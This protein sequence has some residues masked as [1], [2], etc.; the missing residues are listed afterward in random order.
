VSYL[1]VFRTYPDVDHMAPLAWKLLEQGEEVHAIVSPGYD[2]SADHRL[3]LLRGYRRYHEHSVEPAH[4]PRVIASALAF[5]RM[6]LPYAIAF[7]AR[8]NVRLVAV[9]WGYGL[10]EGYDRLAS[11]RGAVA[12]LRSLGRSFARAWRGDPRQP[13]TSYLIAARLLGRATVCLPHG[14]SIKLDAVSATADKGKVFDWSDRNRFDAYVLN[15]EHHRR[16]SVEHAKGDPQVMQTWGSLRWS[17]EWFE[18][19]RRL[20]PPFD[21]PEPTGE[22][23]LKVVLMT[24]KWRNRVHGERV[25]SMVKRIQG[26][27]FVSLAIK[28]HPRPEE[29]R[30]DPLRVD[31]EIDWNRIHDVTGED[32]VSVIRAA[33][34]IIDVGS[35][36]GIETVMQNKVLMNPRYVHELTTF[37][38]VIPGTCVCPDDD[39]AVE[40]YLRDHAAGQPHRVSAEAYEE[41]LRRAVYGSRDE[42][43][44]VI[45]DY[46]RRVSELAVA[47][48]HDKQ[49]TPATA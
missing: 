13:R 33:D 30:N 19:N 44:D 6:T 45:D 32:S 41:L 7:V 4:G 38:D 31:P 23:Q 48:G 29:R 9:E 35:S 14:L 46:Y 10:R 12:V 43:F 26:L 24:P 1:F 36:I 27:D 22:R 8:K 21:W 20:A 2:A 5:V 34:V 3:E 28:G 25:V 16:W 47:N 37:F 49:R 15:T 40:Q 18:L 39:D 42:P 11:V 17:P